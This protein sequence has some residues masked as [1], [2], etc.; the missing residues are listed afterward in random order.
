MSSGRE[1]SQAFY[2]K[3]YKIEKLNKHIQPLVKYVGYKDEKEAR[4]KLAKEKEEAQSTWDSVST[5]V[6]SCI[7]GSKTN[8]SQAKKA[9]KI[10]FKAVDDCGENSKRYEHEPVIVAEALIGLADIHKGLAEQRWSYS[11]S[12]WLSPAPRVLTEIES[13]FKDFELKPDDGVIP[14]LKYR[15][16]KTFY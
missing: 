8:I 9:L 12:H 13:L 7:P 1:S 3:K 4:E 10:I 2:E 5:T 6:Q 14:D 16:F 15:I 11:L